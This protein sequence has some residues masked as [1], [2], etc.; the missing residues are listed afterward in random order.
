MDVLLDKYKEHFG[1]CFPLMLCMGM[2][3]EDILQVIQK[4]LGDDKPYDPDID[5]DNMY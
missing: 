1:E 4:C 5:P 3:E 2:D